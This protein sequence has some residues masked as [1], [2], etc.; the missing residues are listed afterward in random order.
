MKTQFAHLQTKP[1]KR[2]GSRNQPLGQARTSVR[3]QNLISQ[4]NTLSQSTLVLNQPTNDL[5]LVSPR[6][7]GTVRNIISKCPQKPT[8]FRS[9]LP[10]TNEQTFDSRMSRELENTAIPKMIKTSVMAKSPSTYA[11]DKQSPVL[12]HDLM[13][14]KNPKKRISVCQPKSSTAPYIVALK[15][16]YRERGRVSSYLTTGNAKTKHNARQDH[17]SGELKASSIS[18]G[19]RKGNLSA[20]VKGNKLS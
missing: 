2:F 3:P 17:S 14:G 7:P 5:N 15:P 12:N 6:V 9:S 16:L 20:K 10:P 8:S 4:T 18:N 11:R 19:S 1:L 13:D